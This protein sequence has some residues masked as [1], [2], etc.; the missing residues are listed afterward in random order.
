M[1]NI[2]TLEIKGKQPIESLYAVR[3][4]AD[5]KQLRKELPALKRGGVNVIVRN[6]ADR[7]SKYL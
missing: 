6:T 7:E 3:S 4:D 1:Q 5:K 2:L